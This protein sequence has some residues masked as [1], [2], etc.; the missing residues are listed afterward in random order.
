M[1]VVVRCDAGTQ[2][3]NEDVAETDDESHHPDEDPQNDISQQIFEGGY[4]VG[5]GFAAPHIGGITTVFK[6]LKV[7]IEDHG[8]EEVSERALKRKNSRLNLKQT[9]ASKFPFSCCFSW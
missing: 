2:A 3:Y 6:L 1:V 4:P 7:S 9:T 8:R 5:I